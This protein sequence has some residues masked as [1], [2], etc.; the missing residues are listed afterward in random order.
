MSLPRLA[1]TSHGPGIEPRD[2]VAPAIHRGS[3]QRLCGAS[4][5][6]VDDVSRRQRQL[7]QIETGRN[8]T[9]IEVGVADGSGRRQ[10]RTGWRYLAQLHDMAP[11]P[12]DK[13][14]DVLRGIGQGRILADD[15]QHSFG[16]GGHDVAGGRRLSTVPVWSE[17]P[18]HLRCCESGYGGAKHH[19]LSPDEE[20]IAA[21]SDDLQPDG[22]TWI[23]ELA[24]VGAKLRKP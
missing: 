22:N 17:E 12:E 14:S 5:S 10:G 8:P 24:L 2:R 7:A 23:C 13:V 18:V 21:W 19:C 1:E 11:Q 15:Q 9:R 16:R 3:R 4:F 6:S 20:A